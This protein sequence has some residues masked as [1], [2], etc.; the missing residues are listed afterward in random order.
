MFCGSKR[1]QLPVTGIHG[2]IPRAYSD[3]VEILQ[4]QPAHPPGR[5]CEYFSHFWV[6]SSMGRRQG[7]RFSSRL[8][9][10]LSAISFLPRPKQMVTLNC[11]WRWVA[12]PTSGR[13]R[14]TFSKEGPLR[15]LRAPAIARPSPPVSRYGLKN[16]P[17]SNSSKGLASRFLRN[18]FPFSAFQE[19]FRP[20]CSCSVCCG[21]SF[22]SALS[23]N[24][25]GDHL[26]VDHL[27]QVRARFSARTL[28]HPAT[29]PG[30]P[31]SASCDTRRDLI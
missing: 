5:P 27:A 20:L 21:A 10:M 6:S 25:V 4:R 3:G 18:F 17:T 22:V 26:L 8:P 31:E 2:K 1:F 16:V 14:G 15:L 28:T 24:R 7:S 23:R 9:M 12:Q 29:R 11:H 13:K 19:G 30:R